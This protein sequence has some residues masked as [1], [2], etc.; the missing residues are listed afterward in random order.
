[1]WSLADSRVDY[2]AFYQMY[3]YG[4]KFQTDFEITEVATPIYS[5]C[6]GKLRPGT[7]FGAIPTINSFGIVGTTGSDA[8][9]AAPGTPVTLTWN[10]ANVPTRLRWVVDGAGGGPGLVDMKEDLTAPTSVEVRPLKTTTYWL[11]IQ[12]GAENGRTVSAPVTVVV[13]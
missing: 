2:G 5:D 4:P 11:M 3:T 13:R 12:S 10:V 9:P 6:P 1:M 8:S 7:T